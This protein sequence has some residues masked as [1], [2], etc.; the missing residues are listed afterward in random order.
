MPL[1]NNENDYILFIGMV[2]MSLFLASLTVGY[3][4][5]AFGHQ[6]YCGSVFIFPL[7]F[8]ISDV[9]AELYGRRL[10][11]NLIWFTLICECLFVLSTNLVVKMPHPITWHHQIDYNYVVG[12]YPRILIGDILAISFSFYVNVRLISQWKLIWNGKFFFLRS[13]GATAI[14]EIVFTILTNFIA[15]IAVVSYKDIAKIM[16]FD[17]LFKLVYS[18]IAAYPLSLFVAF[19]KIHK[20]GHSD[21]SLLNPPQPIHTSNVLSFTN[22]AKNLNPK[23]L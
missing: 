6:L 11:R 10:A 3:K 17:Y 8:N 19:I 15:F 21:L 23:N 20:Q 13:V 18:I 7:L 14:G 2:Y 9:V 1:K 12:S 5:V 16:L 22:F 4:L